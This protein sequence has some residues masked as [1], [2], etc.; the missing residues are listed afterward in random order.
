MEAEFEVVD[1]LVYGHMIF[2]KSDEF[3]FCTALWT[4]E[5]I[6]FIDAADHLG[7]AS[8]GDMMVF[9]L[10]DRRMGGI[11]FSFAHLPSMRIGVEAVLC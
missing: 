11:T 8:G 5:G 7:P 3:H 2:D 4:D 9:F 10:N 6:D 1:D